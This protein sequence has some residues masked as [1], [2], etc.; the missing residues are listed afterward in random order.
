MYF[1]METVEAIAN[2]ITALYANKITAYIKD[3][4]S[5]D[6]NL[7]QER[8]DRAVIIHNSKPGISEIYGPQHEKR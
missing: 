4:K 8:E 7:V 3:C 6:I 1:R 2:H 5:L